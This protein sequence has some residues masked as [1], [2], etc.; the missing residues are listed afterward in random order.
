M[1]TGPFWANEEDLESADQGGLSDGLGLRW[2]GRRFAYQQEKA[3]PEQ[4]AGRRPTTVG[5]I[6]VVLGRHG[7]D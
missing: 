5:A 4:T 1:N 6:A 7:T 3:F 2:Y